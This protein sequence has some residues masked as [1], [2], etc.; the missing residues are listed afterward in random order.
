MTQLLC[1]SRYCQDV[2]TKKLPEEDFVKELLKALA[3][4]D[5]NPRQKQSGHSAVL[6]GIAWAQV[7]R[8]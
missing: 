4:L 1:T 7:N 8:V 6:K 3:L 5:I 2:S